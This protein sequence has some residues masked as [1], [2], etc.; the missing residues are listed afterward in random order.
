MHGRKYREDGAE[1]TREEPARTRDWSSKKRNTA[2]E[3]PRTRTLK[4][5][6][7]PGRPQR[8]RSGKRMAPSTDKQGTTRTVLVRFEGVMYGFTSICERGRSL[9]RGG[10]V[11]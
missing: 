3:G 4:D 11:V 6:G 9:L 8:T 10:R 5:G 7:E 1:K 2:T